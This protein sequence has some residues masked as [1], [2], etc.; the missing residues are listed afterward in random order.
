MD[1]S[2]L[3]LRSLISLF[4]TIR[5][6]TFDDAK[7]SPNITI[8]AFGGFQVLRRTEKETGRHSAVIGSGRPPADPWQ[9]SKAPSPSLPDLGAT[10]SP[11]RSGSRS[12]C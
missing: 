7:R 4:R 6:K 9:S 1:Y 12:G 3:D 2:F 8:L 11:R 10:S 5:R